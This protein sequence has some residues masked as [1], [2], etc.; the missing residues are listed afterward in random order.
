MEI[1]IGEQTA[2]IKTVAIFAI[3][4]MLY[5]HIATVSWSGRRRRGRRPEQELWKAAKIGPNVAK[6]VLAQLRFIS[7]IEG[8]A[9]EA[10]ARRAERP[11]SKP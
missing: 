6:M 7:S 8:T 1:Q 4:S 5:R 2:K 11:R 3:K 10:A 9:E